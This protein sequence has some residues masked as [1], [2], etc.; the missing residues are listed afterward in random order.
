[1]K[2]HLKPSLAPL[3]GYCTPFNDCPHATAHSLIRAGPGF[4]M[5]VHLKI[6]LRSE[7]QPGLLRSARKL[8][9]GEALP[10]PISE[11]DKACFISVITTRWPNRT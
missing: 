8:P 2:L 6:I 5:L 9:T 7:F 3:A 11:A 10:K 4:A 1:M